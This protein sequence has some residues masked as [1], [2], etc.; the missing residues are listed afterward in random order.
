MFSGIAKIWR[1]SGYR[2][3]SDAT[4]RI[5]ED[6]MPGPIEYEVQRD[7]ARKDMQ[8]LLDQM[9]D[10]PYPNV[11]QLGGYQSAHSH[12]MLGVQVAAGTNRRVTNWNDV[13]DEEARH[14]MIGMRLRLNEAEKF[15]FDHLSTA[16]GGEKVYVFVL[17][18]E[19]PAMLEDDLSLFPSD[20]L[21]SQLRLIQK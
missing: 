12:H 10:T 13:H 9:R 4:S 20:T 19:K 17:V 15:P 16:V 18:D 14:R 3:P 1:G 7:K 8:D 11:P 21:I 5:E 2:H 6:K